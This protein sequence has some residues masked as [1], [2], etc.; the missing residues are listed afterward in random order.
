MTE[1]N[2]NDELIEYLC[3]S[4]FNLQGRLRANEIVLNSL[5]SIIL[6]N[7]PQLI[8]KVKIKIQDVA[9]LSNTM[10]ELSTDFATEAFNNEITQSI[11]KLDLIEDA[12]KFSDTY[13]E[14]KVK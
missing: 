4:L 11:K 9:E 7:T 2:Q 3:G 14:V 5:M 13:I 12:T 6:E 1:K 8:D 10:G